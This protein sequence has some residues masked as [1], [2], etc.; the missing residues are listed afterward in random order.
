MKVATRTQSNIVFG[1]L[2]LVD[3]ETNSTMKADHPTIKAIQN[4]EKIGIFGDYDVDGASSSALL[5]NFF[6]QINLN[7]E[8]YILEILVYD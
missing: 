6:K 5:G 3:P 1:I 4:K 8:V 7:F 2:S